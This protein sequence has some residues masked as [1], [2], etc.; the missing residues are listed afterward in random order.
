MSK[1]VREVKW[2]SILI[3]LCK[4][5]KVKSIC[6]SILS[7]HFGLK[8]HPVCVLNRNQKQKEKFKV[9]DFTKSRWSSYFYIV[10]TSLVTS[11]LRL[12][13][14]IHRHTTLITIKPRYSYLWYR[15]IL[16]SLGSKFVGRDEI[17]PAIGDIV[18]YWNTLRLAKILERFVQFEQIWHIL[19]S[20]IWF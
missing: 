18:S 14:N 15:G 10:A 7:N 12:I 16:I 19:N 20:I 4:T 6:F 8:Y 17:Y 3:N 5:T 13:S 1:V 11:T 2:I 9:F